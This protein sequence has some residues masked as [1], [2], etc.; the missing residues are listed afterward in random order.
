MA[1]VQIILNMQS[2]SLP[3]P[4]K[5]AQSDDATFA[6]GAFVLGHQPRMCEGRS[7]TTS[8]DTISFYQASL[9]LTLVLRAAAYRNQMMHIKVGAFHAGGRR[10]MWISQPALHVGGDSDHVH[11]PSIV[12]APQQRL[13]FASTAL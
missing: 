10:C 8:T 2:C 9:L 13:S 6:V 3:K 4:L 12:S 5:Q 7:T 11:S 1:I